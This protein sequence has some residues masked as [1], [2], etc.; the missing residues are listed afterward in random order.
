MY[1][2]SSYFEAPTNITKNPTS[3]LPRKSKT[4]QKMQSWPG[5]VSSSQGITKL[6]SCAFDHT[7]T[8]MHASVKRLWAMAVMVYTFRQ[9]P[10]TS[11]QTRSCS[12]L[13]QSPSRCA[14]LRQKPFPNHW[15]NHRPVAQVC[16]GR[17]SC[18]SQ[19][20]Q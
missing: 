10:S 20:P 3:W 19:S 7:N 18:P 11:L 14:D 13:Q 12:A 17:H 5:Q 9:W 15:S 4:C 6:E 2:S 16:R 8:T 1:H